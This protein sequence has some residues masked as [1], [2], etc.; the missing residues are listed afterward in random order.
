[1]DWDTISPT[2]A[3]LP[4]MCEPHED[5]LTS[6]F[7]GAGMSLRSS[8]RWRIY[9]HYLWPYRSVSAVIR[10]TPHFPFSFY[11]T[12]RA[13]YYFKKISIIDYLKGVKGTLQSNYYTKQALD[14]TGQRLLLYNFQTPTIN[15]S[16]SGS[17]TYPFIHLPSV[18]CWLAGFIFTLEKALIPCWHSSYQLQSCDCQGLHF[19]LLFIFRFILPACFQQ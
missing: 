12:I 8:H 1:M 11:I 4:V 18:T 16:P 5:M 7:I 2:A 13:L 19:H 6:V 10:Y 17:L 9:F 3:M 15:P 14:R